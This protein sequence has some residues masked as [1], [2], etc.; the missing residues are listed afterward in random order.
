ELSRRMRAS[1][2]R[3]PAAWL[4]AATLACLG[5]GFVACG[6][7]DSFEG[8]TGGGPL[9]AGPETDAPAI[10]LRPD[11]VLA[12]PR[13]IAPLSQTWVA[14]PR[15]RFEWQLAAGA[16][17]ARI[18]LCRSRAC[19]GEKK[20]IDVAG[21]E[22]I[23]DEDLAPGVWFWRLVSRTAESFGEKTSPTWTVRVRGGDSAKNAPN[24]SIVD[25]NGDGRADLL[26]TVE[27]G[28][29]REITALLADNDDSTSFVMTHSDRPLIG[30][31]VEVS[32]PPIAT[33]DIDGDGLSDLVYADSFGGTPVFNTIFTVPGS[34]TATDAFDLDRVTQPSLPPLD[35]LPKLAAAG[36]LDHDGWGDFAI[37]SKTFALATFG[38]SS[39]L[40]TMQYLL[41]FAPLPPDAGAPDGGPIPEP[42]VP[43][44][45]LGGY[46]RNADGFSDLALE[47]PELEV[48]FFFYN[49][50]AGRQLAFVDPQ[51]LSTPSPSPPSVVAA[52]DFD[53]DGFA[54]LALVT[55]LDSKPS[56][57]VGRGAAAL[58]SIHFVCWTP[59]SPATGFGSSL[60]AGDVD[61]DGRDEVIVGSTGAG[62]DILTWSKDA[63]TPQHLETPFGARLTMIL[64]GR[65]EPA[66]WAATR[67]DG[68]GIAVFKGRERVTTLLPPRDALRFGSTIR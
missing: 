55:T 20:M 48:P 62:I 66:V 46:D 67:T 1:V 68:S 24:G 57:C 40:G 22:L 23:P 47:S 49:G 25:V 32:D 8:L 35:S 59:A 42:L 19:D 11:P 45:I 36:D 10:V 17:G 4:A 33:S 12:P 6:P 26:V 65:P 39:G 15:P 34:A 2:L 3:T 61:A 63:L 60:I 56:V 44:S 43:L 21:T 18:E 13:A 52:G 50:G 37:S 54:D 14:A 51:V 9:D 53:G 5:G 27:Y 16:T 38:T 30:I 41:Q 58:D 31:N 7:P 28:N 29:S 64:P